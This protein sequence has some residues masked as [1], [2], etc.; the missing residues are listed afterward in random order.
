MLEHMNTMEQ[1]IIFSKCFMTWVILICIYPLF[2]VE[3]SAGAKIY[4]IIVTD[5]K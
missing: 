2:R 3:S 4:N 5:N 1:T